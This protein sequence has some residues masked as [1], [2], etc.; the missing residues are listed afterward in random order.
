MNS[1]RSTPVPRRIGNQPNQPKPINLAFTRSMTQN[2]FLY[3]PPK[4]FTK[5]ILTYEPRQ[6]SAQNLAL[7]TRRLV[8]SIA[9][10]R[11]V[12]ALFL[13]ALSFF[14]PWLF[15]YLLRRY[16]SEVGEKETRIREASRSGVDLPDGGSLSK[17]REDEGE[18]DTGDA[19]THHPHKSRARFLAD[20]YARFC[21]R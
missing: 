7:R 2:T 9:R 3:V 19:S 13:V 21:S 6:G 20:L 15:F 16:Q 18:S 14:F 5:P 10:V 17:Q 8:V 11:L 4:S 1:C 12:P